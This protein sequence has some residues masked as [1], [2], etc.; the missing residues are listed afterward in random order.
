MMWKLPLIVF[1]FKIVDNKIN[2]LIKY[3][4][5]GSFFVILLLIDILITAFQVANYP[6]WIYYVVYVFLTFVLIAVN[7]I[8]QDNFL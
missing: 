1:S 8:R 4:T 7:S 2:H 5:F 6:D 3:T